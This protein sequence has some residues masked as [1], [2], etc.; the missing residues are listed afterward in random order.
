MPLGPRACRHMWRRQ[1]CMQ[2]TRA[3]DPLPKLPRPR[4]A[5]SVGP[6]SPAQMLPVAF[7]GRMDGAPE[8]AAAWGAVWEEGAPSEGAAVRGRARDAAATGCAC[9][10][11]D[12]RCM[13][14][15]CPGQPMT[16]G[17]RQRMEVGASRSPPRRAPGSHARAGAVVAAGGRASL[18]SMGPQ[19]GVCTGVAMLTAGAGIVAAGGCAQQCPA[20]N[21]S[22]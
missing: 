13:H 10:A 11:G 22:P 20:C 15:A 3:N 9:R 8:V 6:P 18:A 17:R 1:L 4:V 19:E 5:D 21:G 14:A 2:R 7:L 12:R 16:S